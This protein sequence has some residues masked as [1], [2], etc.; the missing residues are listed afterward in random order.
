MFLSEVVFLQFRDEMK[1]VNLPPRIASLDA[2]KVLFVNAFPGKIAMPQFEST[3]QMIYI[4]DME[5]GVYFHLEDVRYV[6]D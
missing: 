3:E 4:K 6:S 1:R 5:T 2:V